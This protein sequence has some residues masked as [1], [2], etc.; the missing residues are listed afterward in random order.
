MMPR[1]QELTAEIEATTDDMLAA[2]EAFK[3][4]VSARRS[5]QVRRSP[6]CSKAEWVLLRRLD[7]LW[8]RRRSAMREQRELMD[9]DGANEPAGHVPQ[10][11]RH[12]ALEPAEAAA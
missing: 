6:D 7:R 12:E 2:C 3:A 8:A 4:E 9:M 11:A 10:P 5:G 1:L